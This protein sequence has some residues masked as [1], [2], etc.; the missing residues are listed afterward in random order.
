MKTNSIIIKIK[1]FLNKLFKKIFISTKQPTSIRKKKQIKKPN[2]IN[3][4]D[5]SIDGYKT[6]DLVYAH[7]PLK[8]KKLN[9]IPEGHRTR[10]YY[11]YKKYKNHFLAFPSTSDPSERFSNKRIHVLS[12][13]S[14]KELSKDSYLILQVPYKL[15]SKKIIHYICTLNSKDVEEINR[16]VVPSSQNELIPGD[17]FIMNNHCYL[18]ISRIKNAYKILTIENPNKTGKNIIPIYAN[19]TMYKVDISSLFYVKISNNIKK[20]NS[21]N[22]GDFVKIKNLLNIKYGGSNC[23][24]KGCLFET[25]EN[26][27]YYCFGTYDN[28]SQVFLV[29]TKKPIKRESIEI[30]VQNKKY[31]II[32][33]KQKVLNDFSN[34]VS[35]INVQ[36]DEIKKIYQ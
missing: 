24:Q 2:I 27:I 11:L 14:Y 17:I 29:T 5:G 3:F 31:Y 25:D 8:D 26:N 20:K 6:G 16:K 30:F 15:N 34:V 23:I 13:N 35:V 19:K 7:M 1:R 12:C 18:Y 36:K 33:N 21:I 4:Y 32:K 9:N 28:K 10:P 22:N